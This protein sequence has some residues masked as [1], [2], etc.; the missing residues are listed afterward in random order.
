MQNNK[1]NIDITVGICKKV[2][3]IG[4]CF[5][6]PFKCSP[7][8]LKKL[9]CLTP[10]S[11]KNNLMKDSEASALAFSIFETMRDKMIGSP[12]ESMGSKVS[13]ITCKSLNGNFIIYWN[14]QGT[15][16]ALRKNLG[17]ALASLNP[18][19]MYSK[20]KENMKFLGAP[21][22]RE[23]FNHCVKNMN[24]AISKKISVAVIGRINTDKNKMEVILDKVFKKLPKLV[25]PPEKDT[26]SPPSRDCTTEMFPHVKCSSGIGCLVLADYISSNSGNMG[27]EVH[28]GVVEV[29]NKGWES[30]RNKLKDDRRIDNYVNQKYNKPKVKDHL[31]LILGYY[32]ITH[33]FADCETL[34]KLIKNNLSPKDISNL[35]K[36][37]I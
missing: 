10:P 23:H 25:N 34:E 6:I 5:S 31:S 20:Y 2:A 36:K 32:A 35:I 18:I 7:C 11:E 19:K 15:G 26:K 33:T 3:D 14:C 28:S 27:V 22:P 21:A 16:S 12:L 4:V 17:L 37:N 24:S 9:L 13:N 1:K 30:K 8:C 29:Y